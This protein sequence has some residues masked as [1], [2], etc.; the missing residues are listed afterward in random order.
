MLSKLKAVFF[1][2]KN[3]LVW[4]S[5]MSTSIVKAPFRKP[6]LCVC[7]TLT[8]AELLPGAQDELWGS[9][10]EPYS[11]TQAGVQ[12][13]DLGSLQPLPPRFK[14]FLI[15]LLLPR[16]ECNGAI[17]A[18]C[19]LRLPGSSNSPASVSC[20]AGTIGT[21]HHAQLIFVTRG[22]GHYCPAPV[23]FHFPYKTLKTGWVQWLMSVIPALWE[24]EGVD[25][26][27]SGV[28]DQL[29]QHGE[30]PS[31]LNIQK[32]DECGGT[33]LNIYPTGTCSLVAHL[34]TSAFQEV[35]VKRNSHD[36]QTVKHRSYW[37]L[38]LGRNKEFP[39]KVMALVW[40]QWCV[41]PVIP[42]LWEDK[43][44]LGAVARACNPNTLGG[45]SRWITLRQEFKTSLANIYSVLRMI[46]VPTFLGQ[47]FGPTGIRAGI[48][49][50][51]PYCR[52]GNSHGFS[53]E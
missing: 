35:T 12:S 45:Q 52:V 32:L 24:V 21:H 25:Y 48:K 39:L 29:G 31:L 2:V 11:V 16:L 15:S 27:R 34:D 9:G 28:Q 17:S 30:T 14:Q 10:L 3:P 26:L 20:L 50:I 13:C 42:A 23:G 33:P 51:F 8:E 37:K 4:V 46:F 43:V 1:Q 40:V 22:A 36:D 41:T 47:F 53:M 7:M 38:T 6:Y 19:N 18:H 5:Q 44:R 49:S